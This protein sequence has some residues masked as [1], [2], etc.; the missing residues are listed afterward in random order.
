ML[1]MQW[2]GLQHSHCGAYANSSIHIA[3]VILLFIQYYTQQN[4]L[5]LIGQEQYN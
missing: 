2:K 4:N 1:Q 3:T 5:I